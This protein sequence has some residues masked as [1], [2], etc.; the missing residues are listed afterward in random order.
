MWGPTKMM[1]IIEPALLLA[2]ITNACLSSEKADVD[3]SEIEASS[4]L[5]TW[6]YFGALTVTNVTGTALVTDSNAPGIVR[7]FYRAISR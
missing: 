1:T 3:P 4:D 7:R 6:T 2:A 5:G